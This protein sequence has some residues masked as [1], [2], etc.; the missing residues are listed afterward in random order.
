MK[1]LFKKSDSDVLAN[2][3]IYSKTN[4]KVNVRIREILKAEQ[5]NFCA[6]SEKYFSNVD[7]VE[8]EHF[9]SS[10][11]YHDDYY[12]Y[13]AVVRWANSGKLDQKFKGAKFF[14]TL[15]FQTKEEFN[16]RIVY[17]SDG[18]YEEVDLNDDEARDLID[19]LRFNEEK[20][21]KDRRNHVQR[22][23]G[24]FEDARYSKKEQLN[25]FRKYPQELSFVTAIEFDLELDL[26]E[27][28]Q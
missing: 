3:L 19:F 23:K 26:S 25:Y 28:Y 7:S 12:N 11:K 8:L 13:Y 10:I 2:N 6:Y 14:E 20:L 22:L 17:T 18:V 1:F 4:S 21:V 24:V 27:F 15:F 9:N 5:K 16:S